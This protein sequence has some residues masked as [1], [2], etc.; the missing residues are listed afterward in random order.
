MKGFR[1]KEA[2]GFVAPASPYRDSTRILSTSMGHDLD[3]NPNI[4]ALIIGMGLW[5]L[6][7]YNHNKKAPQ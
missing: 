5:G 2:V 7:Y 4:G 3:L 6:L 1:V